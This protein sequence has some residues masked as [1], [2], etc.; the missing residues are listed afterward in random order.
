MRAAATRH[1]CVPVKVADL[2]RRLRA[3]IYRHKDGQQPADQEAWSDIIGFLQDQLVPPKL[4][5]ALF[6]VAAT[7]PSTKVILSATDAIGR[8][9]TAVAKYIAS[10]KADDELIFS[11]TFQF[12]GEREVLTE[13][14][15][16]QGSA[17]PRSTT[18][19][20]AGPAPAA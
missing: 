17:A 2:A 3:W 13:P 16:G 10:D 4:A 1:L 20:A 9:G 14:V 5:A 7:I 15:Q 11:G 6:R 19:R 8:P 18:R 12:L